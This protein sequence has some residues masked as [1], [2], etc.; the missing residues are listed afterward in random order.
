MR[1]I[2]FQN[3]SFPLPIG[4]DL[5]MKME[6]E[7]VVLDLYKLNNPTPL[8]KFE[9]WQHMTFISNSIIHEIHL[10]Y[11]L[12]L[13]TKFSTSRVLSI[14]H[15]KT[16]ASHEMIG[17][18]TRFGILAILYHLNL[19]LTGIMHHTV[20]YP[21]KCHLV[22]T[23]VSKYRGVPHLVLYWYVNHRCMSFQTLVLNYCTGYAKEEKLTS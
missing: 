18:Q 1:A 11:F 23:T 4:S 6:N 7:Q 22:W 10:L 8:I 19:I 14:V 2:T 5:I 20:P 9:V 15:W 16:L 12:I 17:L 3:F 13:L 21:H